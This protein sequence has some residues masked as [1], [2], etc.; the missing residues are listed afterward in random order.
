MA[1]T[2]KQMLD[3]IYDQRAGGNEAIIKV[4]DVKLVL[5]G[6]YPETYTE[7]SLDDETVIAKIKIIAEEMGVKL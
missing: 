6:V 5:K 2:I 1:G 4:L 7:T 3:T